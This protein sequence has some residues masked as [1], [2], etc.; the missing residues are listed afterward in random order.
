MITENIIRDFMKNQD[1]GK[2]TLA[3]PDVTNSTLILE[4]NL[5]SGKVII[6]N[7]FVFSQYHDDRLS[8]GQHND[9]EQIIHLAHMMGC[10]HYDPE[11]M[12]DEIEKAKYNRRMIDAVLRNQRSTS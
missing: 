1:L 8:L 11:L 12:E 6:S 3:N 7:R 10:T 5:Q 9:P 4:K 2:M